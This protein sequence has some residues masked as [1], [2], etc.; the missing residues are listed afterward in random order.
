M[1][2]LLTKH[3]ISSHR[4]VI[5]CLVRIPLTLHELQKS[6]LSIHWSS[7]LGTQG[8]LARQ[9]EAVHKLTASFLRELSFFLKLTRM[10]IRK[11]PSDFSS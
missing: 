11:R 7:L 5:R 10:V 9:R 1:E 6:S 3:I 2:S 8:R 4:K